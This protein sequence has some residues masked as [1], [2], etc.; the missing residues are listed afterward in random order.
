MPV[1]YSVLVVSL[2]RYSIL[3]VAQ[4]HHTPSETF[5][6]CADTLRWL[7][8][9]F[10]RYFT[11]FMKVLNECSEE[12]EGCKEKGQV[13]GL[14]NITVQ[15]MSNLLSANIDSGLMHSIS[16]SESHSI[17]SSS[18]SYK[19]NSACVMSYSYQCISLPPCIYSYAINATIYVL[20]SSKP[21]S[22]GVKWETEVW[23]FLSCPSVCLMSLHI[24]R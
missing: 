3:V 10:C 12:L 1:Q 24:C 4:V 18:V 11:L 15:A 16:K 14:R 13:T 5:S 21:S 6:W 2:C 23:L 8:C 19:F 9:L 20:L 17:I 22:A 7:R